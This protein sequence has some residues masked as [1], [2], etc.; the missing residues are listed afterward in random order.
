[1][2]KGSTRNNEEHKGKAENPMVKCDRGWG[3]YRE[4][5]QKYAQGE[6]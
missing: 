3:N 2:I 4:A 5:A 6:F 1:M